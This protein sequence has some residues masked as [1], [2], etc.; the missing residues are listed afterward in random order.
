MQRILAVTLI[1]FC[2][3]SAQ[4]YFRPKTDPKPIIAL[5]NGTPVNGTISPSLDN[6][7]AYHGV[8][9]S[10]FVPKNAK[11]VTIDF[12]NQNTSACEL[13][14][15]NLRTGNG[16]CSDLEY[17][18]SQYFCAAG[19]DPE[20]GT[21]DTP[22]S[23]MITAASVLD[24]L[25]EWIVDDYWYVTIYRN[26][27]L[28][29]NNTCQFSLSMTVDACATA[30]SVGSAD[31]ACAASESVTLPF[32]KTG[33][34]VVSNAVKAYEFDIAENTGRLDAVITTNNVGDGKLRFY[35]KSYGI[36]TKTSNDCASGEPTLSED[37]NKLIYKFSCYVP[38][39]G[40]Y[41]ISHPPVNFDF[42]ADVAV[43]AN[44]C[45]A[46]KGGFDCSY[47]L[48][49]GTESFRA[50][51]KYSVPFVAGSG[52]N[53]ATFQY[54][55]IDIPA[56]YNGSLYRQLEIVTTSDIGSSG[57]ATVHLRKNGFPEDLSY[58]WESR[59]FR[60]DV[61]GNSI[62]KFG[63]N[64][65]DFIRGGRYYL[66]LECATAPKCTFE[67]KFLLSGGDAVKE[68]EPNTLNPD[69]DSSSGFI[70]VPSIMTLI[71]MLVALF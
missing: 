44:V 37:G 55:Y 21:G 36:G 43:T 12:K 24:R 61:T 31:S 57:I 58:G 22:S 60:H 15:R 27:Y 38:R 7:K 4:L 23:E 18:D 48:L 1:F 9:Y 45:P 26:N 64:Q 69:G 16:A 17:A 65:Y 33:V 34:S 66:G 70:I 30:G 14:Y 8:T 39:S 62:S 46:G 40:R 11:S 51:K 53:D 47:T 29:G 3:A 52:L 63:L 41:F 56:G 71:A 10:F 20:Y 35:G 49:N 32:S 42:T 54:L 25:S 5:E 59:D 28:D 50:I 19:N 68:D 13:L 2:I 67:V 6:S